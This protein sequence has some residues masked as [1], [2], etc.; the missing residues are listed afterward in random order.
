MVLLLDMINMCNNCNE[1][2]GITNNAGIPEQ[3][4]KL[5]S[6]IYQIIRIAVPLILVFVG[7]F[8]MAKATAGKDEAEIKKAQTGLVKKAIAAVL[9]FLMLSLVSMLFRAVTNG[10]SDSDSIMSCINSLINDV[11]YLF[12]KQKTCTLL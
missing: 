2:L 6:L 5:V 4:V 7:M 9:V 1:A 11:L 3:V 12:Q 8:D 10:D